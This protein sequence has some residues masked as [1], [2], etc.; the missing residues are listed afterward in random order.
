[1]SITANAYHTTFT[2]IYPSIQFARD[3]VHRR[4]NPQRGL[5]EGGGRGLPT[6]QRVGIEVAVATAAATADTVSYSLDQG[7][8]EDV[9]VAL[10]ARQRVTVVW[11]LHEHIYRTTVCA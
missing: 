3:Q 1:M 9:A 11:L 2:S 4:D 5:R 6:R 7:G 10:S 8:V